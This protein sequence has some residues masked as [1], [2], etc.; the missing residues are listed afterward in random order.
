MLAQRGAP[1]PARP[2]PLGQLIAARPTAELV[3]AAV[4]L[5]GLGQDLA[6]DPLIA[7][8]GGAG[9]VRGDLRAIDRDHPDPDQPRLPAQAEDRGEQLRQR[10]LVAAAELGDRRVVG[11]VVCANH[12]VG[13]VLRT[14]ARSIPREER[15]PL[16]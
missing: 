14:Q 13:D 6:R 1:P 12:P 3:L 2:Q 16:A 11:D 9:G 7:A 15:L 5:G 10:G 4:R 8:V